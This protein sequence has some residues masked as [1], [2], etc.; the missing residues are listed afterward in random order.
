MQRE[1]DKKTKLDKEVKVLEERTLQLNQTRNDLF[2]QLNG[3]EKII[4]DKQEELNE[5][6]AKV[7][8]KQT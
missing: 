5:L 2:K 4:E 1:L 8:V 6:R 7:L 3:M